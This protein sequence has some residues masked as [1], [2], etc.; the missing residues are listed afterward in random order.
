MSS[1]AL[2]LLSQVIIACTW[3][4]YAAI[5]LATGFIREWGWFTLIPFVIAIWASYSIAKASD[6]LRIQAN[7]DTVRGLNG[8]ASQEDLL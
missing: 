1:R 3:L 2:Y 8:P 6:A 7:R 5:C 4:V